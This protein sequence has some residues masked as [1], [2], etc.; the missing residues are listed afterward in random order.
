L[1]HHCHFGSLGFLLMALD[2]V[3][4]GKHNGSTHAAVAE[5]DRSYC[6]WVINA[7][8][9]PRSLL[10]FKTW[11]KNTHGGVL[12]CGK[13]KNG[14]YSE[15]YRDHAEYALWV[16]ELLDP[17]SPLL[18]FQKYVFKREE[19]A[20]SETVPKEEQPAAKRARGPPD[21]ERPTPTTSMDCK[22]CFDRQIDVLFI[23]CRH[24]VCC[25][26]CAALSKTCPVC[27]GHVSETLRVFPG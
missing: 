22:V 23:P 20:A 24:L 25:A 17:S 19:A 26:T 18:E 1:S 13:Y 8:M 27:R 15:I 12:P 11:L 6:H 7:A 16:I 9:L 10:P 21:K 5:T 4:A 3:L 14:F 2:V